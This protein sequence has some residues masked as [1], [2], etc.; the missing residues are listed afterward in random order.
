LRTALR[1][2]VQ[3]VP[4]ES[5][6]AEIIVRNAL[7]RKLLELKA[8]SQNFMMII[9]VTRLCVFAPE[10]AAI[11]HLSVFGSRRR[12]CV[13]RQLAAALQGLN[14]KFP[15]HRSNRSIVLAGEPCDRGV[16]QGRDVRDQRAHGISFTF[17]VL[18]YA[19]SRWRSAFTG[20]QIFPDGES[21]K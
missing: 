8:F 19:A 18:A 5:G 2:G 10:F 1:L 3:G 11:G 6:T 14:D 4:D 20:R 13:C 15:C 21:L 17:C 7:T 9:V 12:I 16:H